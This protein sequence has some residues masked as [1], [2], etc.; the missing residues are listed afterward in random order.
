M[1]LNSYNY[2]EYGDN[3]TTASGSIGSCERFLMGENLEH[4]HIPSYYAEA[5]YDDVIAY[6]PKK[7]ECIWYW[8]KRNGNRNAA[9]LSCYYSPNKGKGQ[10]AENCNQFFHFN[11]HNNTA[12]LSLNHANIPAVSIDVYRKMLQFLLDFGID[13]TLRIIPASVDPTYCLLIMANILNTLPACIAD[14]ISYTIH[15]SAKTTSTFSFLAEEE[16][17]NSQQKIDCRTL[18]T[19]P[20]NSYIEYL[21][22]CIQNHQK[23][24]SYESIVNPETNPPL[25]L[26]QL[27]YQLFEEKRQ[28]V[29]SKIIKNYAKYIRMEEYNRQLATIPAEYASA[30]QNTILPKPNSQRVTF[31]HESPQKFNSPVAVNYRDIRHPNAGCYIPKGL[32][33]DEEPEPTWETAPEPVLKSIQI[34]YRL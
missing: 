22:C 14:K 7:S 8:V 26:Y 1:D 5:K 13:C 27:L 31:S 18:K 6:I 3:N 20:K 2:L 33:P 23:C 15:A 28:S 10:A 12:S 30:A 17:K 24:N 16:W 25:T 19:E 29:S 34:L 32:E 9:I 21:T 11:F 4:F